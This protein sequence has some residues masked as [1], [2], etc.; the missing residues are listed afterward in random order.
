MDFLEAV[1]RACTKDP[2]VKLVAGFNG[3]RIAR[4]PSRGGI[5]KVALCVDCQAETAI[6]DRD[7][8][9]CLQDKADDVL[10]LVWAVRARVELQPAA[11]PPVALSK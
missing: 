2:R 10:E 1:A 4:I 9:A 7:V 6:S 11:D 8:G 5:D 3:Q